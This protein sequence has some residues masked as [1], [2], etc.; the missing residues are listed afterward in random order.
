MK[1]ILI[2]GPRSWENPKPLAK[3][4]KKITDKVGA[5]NLLVIHGGAPGVD[6]LLGHEFNKLGVHTAMIRA[7]WDT[8]HH[9]AGPIRN[10][11]MQ[12]L[13]PEYLLALHWDLR[14]SKGTANCIEQAE[15]NEIPVKFIPVEFYTACPAAKGFADAKANKKK[16]AR[17]R[18]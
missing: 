13:E 17:K 3:V 6:L 8:Y 16:K 2:S 15:E 7:L 10:G 11:V 18:A 1:R 12:T 4:A 5:R 14:D 9:G